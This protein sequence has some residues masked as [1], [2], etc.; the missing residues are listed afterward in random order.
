MAGGAEHPGRF[1]GLDGRESEVVSRAAPRGLVRRTRRSAM[2]DNTPMRI[3]VCAA[4]LAA[5][6][7]ARSDAAVITVPHGPGTPLQDA[8]AAASPGDLLRLEGGIFNEAVTI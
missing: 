2:N 1:L 6:W 8:I 5:L 4:A 7:S 3:L